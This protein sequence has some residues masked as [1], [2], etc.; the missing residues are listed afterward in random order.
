M[1]SAIILYTKNELKYIKAKHHKKIFIA[2]N[3]INYHVIPEIKESIEELKLK[4]NVSE[5]KVVLF[6]GRVQK[7]KKLEVLINILKT[8]NSKITVC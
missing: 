2:N 4:Y 7:R 6:V 5:R 8:K 1:S 3:T